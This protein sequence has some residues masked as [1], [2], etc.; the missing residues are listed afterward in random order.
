MKR[1]VSVTLA[2]A[3]VLAA[4]AGASGSIEKPTLNE[5]YHLGQYYANTGLYSEAVANYRAMIGKHPNTREAERGWLNLASCYYRL[6]L[7]ARS[8]LKKAQERP[9]VTA[10]EIERLEGSVRSYMNDSI[11]SCRKVVAQFPASRAKAIVTMGR[12]YAA[13]GT[14]G[15]EEARARFQQV[16]DEYPEEAAR[17]LLLLGDAFAAAGD[18][19]SAVRT[20]GAAESGFPEVASLAL[21]KKSGLYF[22]SGDYSRALDGSE[23]IIHSLGIDGAYD[24][25]YRPV[26]TVMKLAIGSRAA[27]ERSLGNLEGEAAGYM[28]ILSRYPGTNLAVEAKLGLAGAYWQS[29]RREDAVRLLRGT[30]SEY[31]GSIWAVRSLLRLAELQGAS[32]EAAAT[33]REIIAAYPRS[34]FWVDAQMKLAGL[35]LELEEGEDDPVKKEEL[36]GEARSACNA[37][38]SAYPFCPEGEEAREFLKKKGL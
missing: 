21:L 14:D 19:K 38:I 20:Y 15:E 26:G 32:P 10:A 16:V 36:R 9:G 35:F 18:R 28:E 2:G 24:D 27:A 1:L 8:E 22:D 3:L 30:A 25:S 33:Y 29:E 34:R 31:P 37:V 11:A 17:A 12:T 13:L 6:M 4:S 5:Y 7:Q 23:R